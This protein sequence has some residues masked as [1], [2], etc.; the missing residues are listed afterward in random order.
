MIDYGSSIAMILTLDGS[1]IMIWYME[2]I[3]FLFPL[4]LNAVYFF[5]L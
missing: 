4:C 3:C 2:K 1:Q 5:L